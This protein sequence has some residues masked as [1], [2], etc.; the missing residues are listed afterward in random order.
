MM[1]N[2][3]S[4]ST[5]P[6]PEKWVDALFAKM[7]AYYGNKFADMWRDSNMQSVKA[8][9]HQELSKLTRDEIAAGANALS[10]QE[11][12]PTLPQFIKLCRPSIDFTVAYYEALNGIAA[13]EKGE[14]GEWSH[15]AIFWASTKIGAFDFKHQG[16]SVIKARWEKALGDELA[17]GSWK[18][19]PIAL[20]ALPAASLQA[21]KA[22]ADKY[23]ADTNIIKNQEL[24]S[25]HKAWAKKILQREKENDKTLTQIQLMMARTAMNNALY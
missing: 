3:L 10:T 17:K 5:D 25:D 9:W 14:I 4:T 2:Q 15:P 11:W 13:R 23:L 6:I 18:D 8:V 7:S 20:I 12:C 16:Y 21:T 24:K 19:I 1:T 22:I